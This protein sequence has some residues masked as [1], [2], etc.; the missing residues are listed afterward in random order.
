M[1][2]EGFFLHSLKLKK[3]I[4]GYY[5]MKLCYLFRKKNP[6]FFSIEKV[7]DD[8]ISSF[9]NSIRC[10][11]E[12]VPYN[13]GIKSVFQNLFFFKK[14]SK[15][16]IIHIT[17][18]I[19]YMAFKFSRNKTILTIHDVGIIKNAT[20][21]KKYLLKKIWFDLPLKKLKY[22]TVISEATKKDLVSLTNCK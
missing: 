11:K 16:D 8:I 18:D 2:L 3:R 13:K 5:L 21:V 15:N 19:H 17:G 20:G 22:I 14:S 6:A 1:F 10:Q 12:Y 7:F 4:K 9:K